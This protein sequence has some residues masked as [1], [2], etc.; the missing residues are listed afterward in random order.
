MIRLWDLASGRTI[1]TMRGHTDTIYSL[2]F[3]KDGSLL[4]SGGADD[5]VRLW[6]VKTA[7][8]HDLAFEMSAAM[9]GGEDAAVTLEAA[10]DTKR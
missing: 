7:N 5:S 2:E 1:K 10:T 8:V 6:D 3:S 9:G 4:A